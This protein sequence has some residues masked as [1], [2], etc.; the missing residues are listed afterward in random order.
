MLQ[1]DTGLAL[2]HSLG[3]H[4]ED[5]VHDGRTQ[6]QIKMRL[7]TLLGHT[8]RNALDVTTGSE[9]KRENTKRI[10]V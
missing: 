6:F 3:H 4:V 8:R 5:V 2:T 1:N 9:R 10:L 7:D